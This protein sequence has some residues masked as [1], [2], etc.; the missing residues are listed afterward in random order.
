[1]RRNAI[2]DDIVECYLESHSS[3]FYF[4]M[5]GSTGLLYVHMNN[6]N[7]FERVFF[8]HPDPEPI[9]FLYW[10]IDLRVII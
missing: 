8:V 1:M 10:P 6:L 7:I 5:S 2:P 4:E 9:K 3:Y